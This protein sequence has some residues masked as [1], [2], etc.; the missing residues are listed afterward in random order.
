MAVVL[1][2]GCSSGFGRALASTL[3]QRGDTVVATVRSLRGAP[4]LEVASLDVVELDVTNPQ[5]IHEV[6]RN[7]LDKYGR[8]DVLVNNAGIGLRAPVELASYDDTKLVF[9]TNTFGPLALQ[10]AVLPAMRQQGSG[11]IVNVSSIVGRIVRPFAGVYAASKFALEAISEALYFEVKPFGIRVVLV[12]P[13]EFPT[14]FVSNR[15][16]E[17]DANSPY[18]AVDLD[19][20]EAFT[21]YRSRFEQSDPDDVV[22]AIV[23]AIDDSDTPLRVPVGADAEGIIR[24]RGMTWMSYIDEMIESFGFPQAARQ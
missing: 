6:V 13:G 24:A 1:V 14:K 5:D 10:Q 22:N 15:I 12:E 3:A 8:I 9:E 18:A 21:S 11:L 20:R 2:T 4:L 23:G 7:T 19:W 17:G 16:E